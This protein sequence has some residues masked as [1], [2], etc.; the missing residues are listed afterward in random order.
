[1]KK[2][3]LLLTAFAAVV[4]TSAGAIAATVEVLETSFGDFSGNKANTTPT[5]VIG[6]GSTTFLGSTD[7]TG[8]SRD[9]DYFSFTVPAGVTITSIVI[10]SY[11]VEPDSNFTAFQVFSGPNADLVLMDELWVYDD[12]D[13]QPPL[14]LLDGP[15]TG[16]AYTIYIRESNGSSN[17]QYSVTVN[18]VPLPA[19]A[20]LFGSAILGLVG[21]SRRKKAQ[22]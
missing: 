5:V 19:A 2:I 14:T 8:G 7:L 20:W 21:M 6:A 10:D 13:P 9:E 16:A 4:L 1:M 17:N 18:A 3:S 15:L 12:Q 11:D 22:A